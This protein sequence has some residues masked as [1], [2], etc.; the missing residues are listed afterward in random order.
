RAM[1]EIDKMIEIVQGLIDKGYAYEVSGSVYFR[2]GKVDDYGK[3]S[4]RSVES[5]MAGE[6]AVGSGEK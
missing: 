4:R 1:G 5:M 6:G 3:L 2:V